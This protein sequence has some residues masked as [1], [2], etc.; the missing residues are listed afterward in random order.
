MARRGC[1]RFKIDFISSSNGNEGD[2]KLTLEIMTDEDIKM[3]VTELNEV[4]H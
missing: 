4:I 1:T 3:A 2:Q